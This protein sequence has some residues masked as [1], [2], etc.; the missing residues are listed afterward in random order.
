ML[1]KD[2]VVVGVAPAGSNRILARKANF[3]D[4]FELSD[5]VEESIERHYRMEEKSDFMEPQERRKA[6]S[7]EAKK[8]RNYRQIS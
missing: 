8:A 3:T 5:R 7:V 2:D 6:L 1:W 4:F